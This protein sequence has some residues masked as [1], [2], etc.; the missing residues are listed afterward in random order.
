MMKKKTILM[1]CIAAAVIGFFISLG[2]GAVYLTPK[3]IIHAIFGERTTMRDQII[4]NVRL[5]RTVVA[6]LVGVLVY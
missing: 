6:A 4:W 1:L 5:P 3:E 2:N